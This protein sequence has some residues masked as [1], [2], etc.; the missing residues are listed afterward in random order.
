MRGPKF[1]NHHYLITCTVAKSDLLFSRNEG[2]AELQVLKWQFNRSFYFL[3]FNRGE[4][5]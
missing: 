5:G 4:S 2:L 3:P 1:H